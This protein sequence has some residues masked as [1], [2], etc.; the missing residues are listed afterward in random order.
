MNDRDKWTIRR[1]ELAA[2]LLATV[3]AK[4]KLEAGM[5]DKVLAGADPGK[6]I[7]DYE[8]LTARAKALEHT[9]N[10]ADVR[11]KEFAKHEQRQAVIEADK[12]AKIN[13]GEAK[14]LI[15]QAEPL[16]KNLA[17]IR[18]DIERLARDTSALPGQGAT[19]AHTGIMWAYY[20]ALTASQEQW[21]RAGK[22]REYYD[23]VYPN[24]R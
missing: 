2:D 23:R 1:D 8:Q 5:D 17:A 15:K 12:Q 20:Q 14:K 13:A 16:I 22:R 19:T 6:L 7:A 24:G 3:E 10:I 9:L 21:T 18:V 4:D 11:I